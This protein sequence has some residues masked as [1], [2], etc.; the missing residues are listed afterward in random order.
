MARHNI[1]VARYCA[2]SPRLDGKS[3]TTRGDPDAAADLTGAETSSALV[4]T[5]RLRLGLS[6]AEFAR[7]FH[8]LLGTPR[9]WEQSGCR[10]G[11]TVPAYLRSIARGPDVLTRTFAAWSHRSCQ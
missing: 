2:R 11:M 10:P 7:R 8:I 9:D 3:W 5:V 4:R 1:N 6:R